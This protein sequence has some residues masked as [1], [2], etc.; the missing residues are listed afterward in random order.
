MTSS[1]IREEI[2]ASPIIAA[3]KDEEGLKR[4]LSS[5]ARII[6][7][8]FGTVCNIEKIVAAIKDSG[9]IAMVHLDLI[10]GLS[11]AKEV[12]VDFIRENTR[13]DGI[14]STRQP[15]IRR[16]KELGLFTVQRFFL[17]DSMALES[18]K[19]LREGCRPDVIEILPGLMPKIIR[20]I[21][22]EVRE[23]VIAGGL[24]TDKEDIIAALSAGAAGVST[25]NEQVWFL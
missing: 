14:I 3:V 11:N 13:A 10:A 23:P 19:R 25:T 12:S 1:E 7:A 5:A 6:F 9:R 8:L 21:C 15:L 2:T 17:L 22:K 18:V 24:I 4:S 16:G 20:Q